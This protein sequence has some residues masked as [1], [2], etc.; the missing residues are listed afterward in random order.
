MLTISDWLNIPITAPS[1][2]TT[3]RRCGLNK[4][5]RVNAD[6]ASSIVVVSSTGFQSSNANS[7]I[8][9]REWDNANVCLHTHQLHLW[10]SFQKT[11]CCKTLATLY[12]RLSLFWRL[13]QPY[14]T[15]QQSPNTCL[16]SHCPSLVQREYFV[17]LSNFVR[18]EYSH[19]RSY[20]GC[21][22]LL[23]L[24]CYYRLLLIEI[25]LLCFYL[26]IYHPRL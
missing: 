18:R 20:Q 16:T 14:P 1:T 9:R 15:H 23:W 26:S 21:A 11:G 13:A 10:S 25:C 24:R 22:T 12:L 7:D 4:L 17:Q 3:G 19:V 5:G 2:F 6:N 8:A